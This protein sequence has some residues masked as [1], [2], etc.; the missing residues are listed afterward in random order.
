M[1]A[2]PLRPRPW[3]GA[4]A[5]LAAPA[6]PADGVGHRG[7][8]RAGGHRLLHARTCRTRCATRRAPC[9]GPTSP[10]AARRRSRRARRRVIAEL[11]GARRRARETARVTQLRGHGLRARA[12][13]ARAS[14]RCW[15]SRAA[16]P[17]T[18]ASRPS[19][20][21]QWARL[22]ERRRRAR[23]PRA[24]HRA[25]RAGRRHPEPGRG[26]LRDPRHRRQHAGRRR[27]PLRPGPARLPARRRRGRHRPP[28]LRLPRALRGLP[29]A[30]AGARTRSAWPTAYRA[31]PRRRARQHPH[32]VRGPA[33]A[34]QQP[35]AGWAATSAWSA[36]WRCSWAAW[37]WPARCTCSSRRR[38]TRSRCCAAWAPPPAR[39]SPS[40]SSRRWPW[41]WPA[42]CWA[43]PSA[44]SCSAL[45]PRLFAGILPVD[46]RLRAV[47]GRPIAAGLAPRAVGGRLFALLP[48]LAI[49]DVSAAGR[50]APR[51]RDQRGGA[52]TRAASLA[53]AALG[54]ER[55]WPSSVLQA[56]NPGAGLV[57][58]AA[59]GGAL[60]AAVG[61]GRSCS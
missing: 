55:A 15:P 30:A 7:R 22:G 51:L 2:L 13:R 5:G 54:G 35:R 21:G 48:L 52:A 11:R 59:I 27:H 9:W 46:V 42:A 53:A 45:L 26:A 25:R 37:A 19:P 12:R 14:C 8:G 20:P 34:Q 10:W 60:G 47:A 39:S 6:G 61:R 23:R 17:S 18:A 3:P 44:W 49:R 36:W 16:I 24:A 38:W 56:P 40:T 29:E 43:R 57:F 33:L 28:G 32:G 1:S 41:A 58:A 50:A 31:A 4:R